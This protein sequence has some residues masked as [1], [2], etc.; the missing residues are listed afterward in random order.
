MFTA[1]EKEF[2]AMPTVESIPN[3]RINNFQFGFGKGKAGALCSECF[4]SSQNLHN[5]TEP[6]RLW[7]WEVGT[8]GSDYIMRAE[9][10]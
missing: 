1:F 5:E 6:Q 9:P 3:L 8:L 7:Y 10:S 2:Q 4:V